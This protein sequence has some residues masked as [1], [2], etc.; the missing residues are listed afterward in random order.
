MVKKTRL[1]SP[2][3]P[4]EAPVLPC[5]NTWPRCTV[6]TWMYTPS[7]RREDPR[8]S[9]GFLVRA[10]GRV[11]KEQTVW[12]SPYFSFFL[13]SPLSQRQMTEAAWGQGHLLEPPGVCMTPLCPLDPPGPRRRGWNPRLELNLDVLLRRHQKKS[14]FRSGSRRPRVSWNNSG[15]V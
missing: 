12:G 7:S 2:T 8:R 4:P 10:G 15:N 1:Q 11:R 5:R 6:G 3:K 13:F 9:C 14:T